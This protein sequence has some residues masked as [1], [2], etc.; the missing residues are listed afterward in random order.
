MDEAFAA[1]AIIKLP[2][3]PTS[4]QAGQRGQIEH[5]PQAAVEAF[6]PAQIASDATRILRYRNKSGVGRQPPGC[7]ER[8][9]VT[10]SDDE[11]FRTQV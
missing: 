9:Q 2:R 10:P 11:E 1:F 7:G 6:R 3:R 5:P 8:R 4:T